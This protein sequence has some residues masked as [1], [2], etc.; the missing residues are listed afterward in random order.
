MTDARR[1]ATESAL[2]TPAAL[3]IGRYTVRP[4]SAGDMILASRLGL[5]LVSGDP[6]K[7]Q[8]MTKE[9]QSFE[10]LAL[11]ALLCHPPA[12]LQASLWSGLDQLRSKIGLTLFGFTTAESEQMILHMAT[13]FG[14]SAA[15]DF[16]LEEKPKPSGVSSDSPAGN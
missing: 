9:D 12:E 13:L 15:V 14:Q 10:L 4:F 5:I 8:S 7:I 11:A 2:L 16:E 3:T 6:E 1:A